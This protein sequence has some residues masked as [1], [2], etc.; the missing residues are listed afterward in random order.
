MGVP[1]VLL[2]DHPGLPSGLARILRDLVQQ[3]AQDASLDLELAV[4]GWRPGGLGP[5]GTPG[6]PGLPT[7][8]FS[9]TE[10]DQEGSAAEA[11]ETAYRYWF[12]TRPGVVLT[13]WD[14]A[15][16]YGVAQLQGPWELWGY[17]PLDAPMVGDRI[18][19][20]ALVALQAYTRVLA[21]TRWGSRLLR[22]S[23]N[24]PI[25]YLPHGLHDVW[26]D[27]TEPVERLPK[28]VGIVATNQPRKDW[29][30]ALG[31]CAELR[32]RGHKVNV[33]GHT[34]RAVGPAWSLP[35]LVDGF[36]L[37]K[38]VRLTYSGL[39]VRD[40]DLRDAYRS[41]SVTLHPGLGEGFCYPIVESQAAG[42]PPVHTTFGG[43]AELVLRSE[44]RVPER[45]QRV[46]GAHALVRPVLS[47]VDMANAVERVWD[48]QARWP[49][50]GRGYLAHGVQYL[51]WTHLWPRWRGW[52]RKGLEA[53]EV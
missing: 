13:V 22:T 4:V 30:L 26:W 27:G 50:E 5:D 42:T 37:A 45:G 2:G 46:E 24:R 44:W 35:Q 10:G 11:L 49:D 7:W 25:E 33:W 38:R 17:M 9:H 48:W 19:G 8:T 14:P 1:F 43:G 21:Y 53:R 15:R 23:L 36:G 34:D 20:P 47:A 12:G 6:V 41:A 52:V 32:R 40:A 3:L 39:D 28:S 29:P 16:C 31:A 51:R 18:F